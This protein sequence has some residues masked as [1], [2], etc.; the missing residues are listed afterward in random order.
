MLEVKARMI[1]PKSEAEG[2]VEE[3]LEPFGRL[4][5]WLGLAVLKHPLVALLVL[6]ALVLLVW[7]LHR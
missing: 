4:V 1:V 2:W 7:R 6:L 5:K 3:L